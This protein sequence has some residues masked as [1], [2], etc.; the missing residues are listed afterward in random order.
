MEQRP[1]TTLFL[2]HISV[3]DTSLPRTTLLPPHP[4]GAR[5]QVL[6]IM[7]IIIITMYYPYYHHDMHTYIIIIIIIIV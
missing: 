3:P 4:A 1:R 7:F 6:N 2:G 5:G